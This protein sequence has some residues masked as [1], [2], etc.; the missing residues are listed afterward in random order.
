MVPVLVHL[1]LA[2]YRLIA[3]FRTVYAKPFFESYKTSYLYQRI[4]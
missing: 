1:V 3:Q 4:G 2:N